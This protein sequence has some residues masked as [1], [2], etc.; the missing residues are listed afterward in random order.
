[1]QIYIKTNYSYHRNKKLAGSRYSSIWIFLFIIVVLIAVIIGAYFKYVDQDVLLKEREKKIAQTTQEL[2]TLK[3]KHLEQGEKNKE[4]IK[5]KEDEIA[6]KIKELKTQ[7]QSF[8]EQSKLIDESNRIASIYQKQ[9]DLIKTIGKA[10]KN[11][12][13]CYLQLEKY[14]SLK[15]NVRN[16]SD[17]DELDQMKRLKFYLSCEEELSEDYHLKIK[18]SFQQ[19]IKNIL[20]F[21]KAQVDL[22]TDGNFDMMAAEQSHSSSVP[23][24]TCHFICDLEETDIKSSED[25]TVFEM[26]WNIFKAFFS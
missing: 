6:Q 24:D 8:A 13:L 5:G 22:M 16:S 26:G 10:I 9:L 15:A 25:T 14:C 3:Q 1:M 21:R 17:D 23:A 18:D 4:I 2:E 20:N 12:D 11:M 19:Y 7:Q